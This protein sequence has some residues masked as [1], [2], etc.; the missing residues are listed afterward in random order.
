[1]I[2]FFQGSSYSVLSKRFTELTERRQS[3]VKKQVCETITAVLHT[4]QPNFRDD[5]VEIM[6]SIVDTNYLDKFLS[7]KSKANALLQQIIDAHNDAKTREQRI[8]AISHIAG[9]F[10]LEY[11]LE[12]NGPGGFVPNLTK[13]IFYEAKKENVESGHGLLE[14]RERKF[15]RQKYNPQ[16]MQ[17]LFDF[18]NSSSL[19]QPCAYGTISKKDSS[20]KKFTMPKI[21][22]EYE[23]PKLIRMATSYL[24]ELG[25]D[26]PCLSQFYQIL[27]RLPSGSPKQIKG[28]NPYTVSI[29]LH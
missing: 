18:L 3:E 26:P 9:I 12:F 20:G 2:P 24:E 15:F 7:G 11:L 13:R 23:R 29:L 19:I 28:V 27:D 1:M 25:Y 4:M 14:L 16:M 10:K 5:D 22:R 8:L 21:V 6:K 17:V